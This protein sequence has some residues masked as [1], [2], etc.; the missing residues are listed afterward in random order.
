MNMKKSFLLLVLVLLLT[1]QNA[2]SLSF[3]ECV[4]GVVGAGVAV[5]GAPLAL[6]AVGFGAT[7]VAAGSAA[8]AWQSTI[9][10]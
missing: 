9:G 2:F 4:A 8:A 1:P 10:E 6:G 3:G 7:G 5:V